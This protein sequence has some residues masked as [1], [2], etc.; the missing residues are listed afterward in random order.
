M[1]RDSSVGIA[2]RYDLEGRVSNCRSQ[3]PSGL[4]RRSAADLLLRLRVWIPP[5]TIKTKNQVRMKYKKSANKSR[6]GRIFADVQTGRGAHPASYTVGSGSFPWVKCPACG[7]VKE[8]VELYHYS[9]YALLWSVLG[10]NLS[11][12]TTPKLAVNLRRRTGLGAITVRICCRS[13]IIVARGLNS[14]S[15][16]IC[17][18]MFVE[19]CC[20]S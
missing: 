4:R 7:D 3:W 19:V 12:F 17:F 6:W 2:T 13:R 5:G 9:P 1:C 11:F 14:D 15:V 10:R 16:W 8:R 18:L 20:C